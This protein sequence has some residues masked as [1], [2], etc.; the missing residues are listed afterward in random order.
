MDNKNQNAANGT[1]INGVDEILLTSAKIAQIH[2]FL[3]ALPHL[4]LSKT[5]I[6]NVSKRFGLTIR[7]L[8]QIIDEVRGL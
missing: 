5:G 7:Q 3:R 6:N 8:N 4:E 1:N 2:H